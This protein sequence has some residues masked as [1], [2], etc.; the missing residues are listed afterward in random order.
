MGASQSIALPVEVPPG[1][2][3]D[4]SVSFTAPEKPG[5]YESIWMLRSPAG[6][7][8][9]VGSAAN[10]PVW[11]KVRVIP[12]SQGTT[13]TALVP[14]GTPTITP[15]AISR[16]NGSYDFAGNACQAEWMNNEGLLSCPGLEGE[17]GGA[18]LP[19]GEARL[20][21]GT[22][23]QLPSLLMLPP[24]SVVGLIQGTYPEYEVQAGDHFQAVVGCQVDALPC[25]VLFKVA[26]L[27][28]Q[29]VI[30]DLWNI[31]EFYDGQLFNVDLDLT[32]LAGQRVR[33]NL[34]VS[35]LGDSEGDR[36]LWVAP[37]ILRAS[38][39][40]NTPEP[41]N[42]ATPT[43]TSVPATS[44]PTGTPAVIPVT[45]TPTPVL[46]NIPQG[47]P[48]LFEQLMEFLVSFFNSLFGN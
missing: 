20:E 17:P 14:Q 1:G 25:S 39:P 27:D 38:V 12:A 48:S 19:L 3:V 37:G 35:S 36:A 41:V 22:V 46:G 13:P 7:V 28:S 43:A 21:N 5:Y 11:A 16:A 23:L 26:Y 42:T 2:L 10:Q 8:F 24:A 32:P 29:G 47:S 9:G 30:N 18:V 34:S 15:T 45:F 44:T 4:I 40:V 6:V 31:G 33:F